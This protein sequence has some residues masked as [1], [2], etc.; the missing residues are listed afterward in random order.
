MVVGGGETRQELIPFKHKEWS[1][2][3]VIEVGV[4]RSKAWRSRVDC[5]KDSKD[6]RG[7]SEFEIVAYALK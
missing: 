1:E 3:A 2:L 6:A 7:S 5:D 4:W